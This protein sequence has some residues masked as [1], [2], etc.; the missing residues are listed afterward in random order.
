MTEKI[1]AWG[2]DLKIVWSLKDSGSQK[3]TAIVWQ[4]NGQKRFK[5]LCGRVNCRGHNQ[6]SQR[7][8][9]GYGLSDYSRK[10]PVRP[11]IDRKG[12]P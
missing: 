3:C 11:A 6:V 1:R 4:T 9:V 10:K 12:K 8:E 5:A 2:E 7:R